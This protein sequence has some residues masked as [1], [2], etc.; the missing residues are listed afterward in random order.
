[1]KTMDKSGKSNFHTMGKVTFI[2][3]A[4]GGNSRRNKVKT[5]DLS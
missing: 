3:Q 4:Q 2:D 1:M 5:K